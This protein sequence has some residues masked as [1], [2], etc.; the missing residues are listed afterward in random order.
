MVLGSDF[1]SLYVLRLDSDHELYTYSIITTESNAQLRF[2]H[3]RMPVI[4][5]NGSEDVGMWL[6]PRRN[7][8]SEELQA[9]LKPFEG[10]LE[11]YAVSGDVGKV[12]NDSPSFVVPVGSAENRGNIENF[13]G[14]QRGKKDQRRESSRTEVKREH[15]DDNGDARETTTLV[16][17]T[18]DNAP[19]PVP[20]LKSES[21]RTQGSEAGVGESRTAAAPG[22]QGQKRAMSGPDAAQSPAKKMPK[23]AAK[24]ASKATRSATSN[25]SATT[26]TR[27]RQ[28]DGSRKITSFFGQK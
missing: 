4:L 21:G 26:K 16:E 23:L 7:E 22:T 2:L 27:S 9:L 5:E 15:D 8:W 19:L 13:F 3:D 17:S 14:A 11:C 20:E 24:G 18:E 1:F 25:G 10:E 28:G 6:D 12:G